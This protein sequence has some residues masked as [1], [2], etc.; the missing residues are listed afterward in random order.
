MTQVSTRLIWS[1]TSVKGAFWLMLLVFFPSR[2]RSCFPIIYQINVFLLKLIHWADIQHPF[3]RAYCTW[4][5]PHWRSIWDRQYFFL[6]ISR[7]YSVGWTH[8]GSLYLTFWSSYSIYYLPDYRGVFK[9]AHLCQKNLGWSGNC[10]TGPRWSASHL[11]AT[12][13]P[14]LRVRLWLRRRCTS[15]KRTITPRFLCT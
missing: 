7:R 13:K 5:I 6:Q 8:S 3:L 11:G 12:W 4:I 10:E 14:H 1:R 15:K 9:V 2:Q